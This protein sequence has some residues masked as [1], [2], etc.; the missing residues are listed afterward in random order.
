VERRL[1]LVNAKHAGRAAEAGRVAGTCEVTVAPSRKGTEN[2]EDNNRRD[3][4]G[5]SIATPANAYHYR[6]A[7]HYRQQYYSQYQYD[8]GP[9]IARGIF[10]AVVARFGFRRRIYLCASLWIHYQPY[11]NPRLY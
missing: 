2:D 6:N 8:P 4:R 5:S 7:H 1:Q 10:G 9:A 11:C 3:D